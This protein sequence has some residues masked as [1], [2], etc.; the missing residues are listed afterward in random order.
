MKVVKSLSKILKNK[1]FT[2]WFYK[3]KPVTNIDQELVK[4]GKKIDS[5]LL[6]KLSNNPLLPDHLN[7]AMRYSVIGVGKKLKR[8]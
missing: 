5:F 3:E 7:S 1:L 2:F 6:S 8:K 4:V